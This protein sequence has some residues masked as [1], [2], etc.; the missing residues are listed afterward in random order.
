[1]SPDIERAALRLLHQD[2]M[3]LDERRWDDWL[4]LYTEDSAFWVPTWRT[5]EEL[6]E[7]PRRELSH[8]F[9]DNRAALAERVSRVRSRRSPATIPMPRTAHMIGN[10]EPVEAQGGLVVLRSSWSC[11]V[12]MPREALSH[13]YFGRVDHHVVQ[14]DAGFRI[15]AKHVTLLNEIVPA[16]LDFFCV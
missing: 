2:G 8:M 14:A 3:F 1:M 10:T 13:T 12:Y 5:E 6:T 4:S 15:R 7:N 9:F 11:S 16:S